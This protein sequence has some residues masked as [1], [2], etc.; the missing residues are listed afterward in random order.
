MVDYESVLAALQDECRKA[1]DCGPLDYAIAVLDE[2]KG[3]DAALEREAARRIRTAAE[4]RCVELSLQG[5]AEMANECMGRIE[6]LLRLN[7]QIDFDAYMLFME[8]NR[9]PAKRF[10]APRRRVFYPRIVVHMQDLA[11]G[12]LDFLSVSCPPRV[13]KST[14][15]IFFLTWT[16]GRNPERANVMTGHSDALTKGFHLE[17]L[18][19][20]SDD[21]QYRFAEVFPEAPLVDKSMADETISLKQTGRFPSLT[22]RSIGGTLTGAVEVGPD[23]LLYMDDL[24]E[25]REEALNADRMEKLYNAYLNQ[26]KDRMKENARQLCV[27]TRWVPDDPIGRI[28]E[29]YGDNP[30]YRFVRVPA[31]DE[32][33]ESNFDFPYGVGFTTAYY[34]D[35]RRS[36]VSAGE[37]DSWSA[38]YMTDPYSKKGLMFNKDDL[39]YF[40]Q[41]PDGEPDAILA[42]CDPKDRGEDYASVAIGLVYGNDHYIVDAVFDNSLPGVFKPRIANAMVRNHVQLARFESNAAGGCVADDVGK[43][44]KEQNHVLSIDKKYSTANKE[45]RILVDSDWIKERCLF[46]ENAPHDDYR[47]WFRNVTTYKVGGGVKHDDGPD[48]LS[49]YKRLACSLVKASAEPMKRPW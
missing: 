6:E 2:Y 4:S 25:D 47:R 38:K 42:A 12:K 23:A 41:L 10:Y 21:T 48:S 3:I 45:T 8:W 26:L 46:W 43:M 49:M 7:A 34:E 18:S 22:C 5:D 33:G 44:V 17:A 40:N 27:A 30:R 14:L 13:G 35:M 36:L 1:T 31:L 20:I 39:R 37:Q 15:G 28:E 32:R 11:D 24:V 19:L 29:D 16:M 9:E